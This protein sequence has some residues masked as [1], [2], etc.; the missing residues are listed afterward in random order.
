MNSTGPDTELAA[1]SYAGKDVRGG[2]V[3]GMKASPRTVSWRQTRFS[4][5]GPGVNSIGSTA[6]T[7]RARH[8]TGQ[9]TFAGSSTQQVE[10]PCI[11]SSSPV[12][13]EI[14]DVMANPCTGSP[15]RKVKTIR[16]AH[17]RRKTILLMM[18]ERL[19][20]NRRV[21]TPQGPKYCDKLPLHPR[22]RPGI[23]IGSIRRAV[24][25]MRRGDTYV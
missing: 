12:A 22:T 25:R 13:M 21:S 2:G 11:G 7:E 5:D 17:R 16:A 20:S 23:T 14:C 9:L 3:S 4:S 10:P 19:A 15:A 8:N 18:T 1:G 6:T 24:Y